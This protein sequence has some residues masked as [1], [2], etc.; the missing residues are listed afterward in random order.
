MFKFGY[1]LTILA[2]TKGLQA[3]EDVVDAQD[4]C[5]FIHN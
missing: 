5:N 3:V 2:M 4:D 1:L